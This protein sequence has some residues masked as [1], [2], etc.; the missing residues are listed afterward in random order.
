MDSHQHKK[1]ARYRALVLGLTFMSY[2]LFHMSRKAPSIVK[3]PLHPHVESAGGRMWNPVTNPG[4]SPFSDDLNP[5]VVAAKGYTVTGSNIC[6][7]NADLD[8]IE[9][10]VD[11]S[12]YDQSY[13]RRFQS[14]DQKFQMRLVDANDPVRVRNI[15]V[16]YGLEKKSINN[17]CWVLSARYNNLTIHEQDAFCQQQNNSAHKSCILYVQPTGHLIPA[18]ADDKIGWVS[19][20]FNNSQI[21]VA[22]RVENGKVLLGS[23]D[24]VYLVFYAIGL[25]FSGHIADSMSIKVF[26]GLGMLGSGLFVALIGFGKTLDVHSLWYFYSIYAVQGLFQASGWP[27]V[28]AAMANWYPKGSRGLVMGIWNAHTSVGNILGSLVSGAALGLGM[29]GADWPAAFFLSGAL[30]AVGGVIVLL[31]LPNHPHDVGLPSMQELEAETLDEALLNDLPLFSRDDEGPQRHRFLRALMIPGVLE[32]SFALFFAK[33][34]AYMFIYWLPYYLGHLEFSATDAANLSTAFDVGG[35]VGGVIAGF[36]SDRIG[37]RAPVVFVYLVLSVPSLYIYREMS[38]SIGDSSIGLNVLLMVVCGMFVNG[39][40]AL[41]TTAVSADLGQHPSLQGDLSLTATVT[42]IVDGT[43]SIGASVQ[44]V[45]IGIVASGCNGNGQSW[46]AVFYLLM[47]CCACSGVCILRLVLK[48]GP[49]GASALKFYYFIV[50]LF[51]LALLGVGVYCVIQVAH[52]CGPGA[53]CT[54][55]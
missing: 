25:F 55:Y 13:C 22:P 52:A 19:E 28:V 4:W 50:A 51:T 21:T 37:R 18:P 9:Q 26:L 7:A 29:N 2:M 54:N 14:V 53:P 10:D 24:T 3:D 1:M 38:A 31:F 49:S 30:I 8:C 44:G 32:F 36:V 11:G 27:S 41:I 5:S 6:E 20:S 34:V 33:F 43:G 40:Y 17:T 16:K 48:Q 42:G 15:C 45:L 47:I 39:P 23:C 46:D 35:V 12:F